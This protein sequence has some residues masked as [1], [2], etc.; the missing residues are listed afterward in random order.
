M[1]QEMELQLFDFSNGISKEGI[2][3]IVDKIVINTINEGNIIYVV[4]RLTIIS[5]IIELAKKNKDFKKAVLDELSK[6]P[7][8]TYC[9]VNGTVIEEIETSVE[10]NYSVDKDW[11][12]YKEQEEYWAE[13]RKTRESILKKAR[14]RVFVDE[15]T[16]EVVEK[17]NKKSVTSFKITIPLSGES[18]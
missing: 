5:K 6:Y 2:S 12:Y 8:N 18:D 9:S 3:K 4:E 17:I 11:R 13:L 7:N 14:D 1:K 16:G 15:E 10:Y